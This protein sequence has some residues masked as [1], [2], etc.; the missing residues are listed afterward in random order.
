MELE[1]R[2]SSIASPCLEFF[3]RLRT[4]VFA[5]TIAA[6]TRAGWALWARFLLCSLF[7]PVL[8]FSL[9]LHISE[10]NI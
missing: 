8:P 2:S 3:P 1:C 7:L 5:V 6:A 4:N 9:C 10:L